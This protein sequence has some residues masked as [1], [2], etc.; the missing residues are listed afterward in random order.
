[1][2]GGM[3][4]PGRSLRIL[5]V[6]DHVDSARFLA[7]LLARDAHIVSTAHTGADALA[8]AAQQ[9][10]DVVI[11]DLGLP[12]IAG[13]D[14]M[15]ALRDQHQAPGI[16]LSGLGDQADEIERAR[17]AGFTSCLPKPIDMARLRRAL[18]ALDD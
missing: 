5:L 8:L 6:E 18:A 1:M 7:M 17:A 15:A 2:M 10:F 16:M 9:P 12:D 3:G 11:C 13:V 4:Q 14:V